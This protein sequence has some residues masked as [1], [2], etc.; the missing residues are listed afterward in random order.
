MPRK[1]AP[2]AGRKPKGEFAGKTETFTTRITPETRAALERGARKKGVSLSQHV[3]Y[4]LRTALHKPSSAQQRNQ[5]LARA[6]AFLAENIERETGRGWRDDAFT[7]QALRYAVEALL[8]HFAPT[9]QDSL[10]IPT[11]IEARASKMPQEFAERYRTP[12]GLGHLAAYAMICEVES[13][14]KSSQM[15]NEWTTPIGLHVPDDYAQLLGRALGSNEG[16]KK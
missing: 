7:G 10:M 13:A 16:G 14:A 2:G 5:A 9:P 11:P 12:A 15:I 8:F 1:R 3:E 4:L 6:I